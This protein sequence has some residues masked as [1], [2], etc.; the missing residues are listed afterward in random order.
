MK[1]ILI[2]LNMIKEFNIFDWIAF[3]LVI[4]GALNW[5][6]VGVLNLDL[7][8]TLFGDMSMISR[9]VYVLVG[10]SAIYVGINIMNYCRKPQV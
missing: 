6:L 1:L 4:V 5:G 7:V 8:A 2:L 3:V 9:I 10:I